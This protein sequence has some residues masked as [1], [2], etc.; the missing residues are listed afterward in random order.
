VNLGKYLGSRL[1]RKSA[2]GDA[3][4][5]CNRLMRGRFSV[6]PLSHAREQR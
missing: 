3:L 5:S 4:E 1:D 2:S 6:K